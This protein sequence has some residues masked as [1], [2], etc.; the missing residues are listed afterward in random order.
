M[1]FCRQSLPAGRNKGSRITSCKFCTAPSY[2]SISPCSLQQGEPDHLVQVLHSALVLVNV[3]HLKVPVEEHPRLGTQEQKYRQVERMYR[4][5]ERMYRQVDR[6]YRQVEMMYRQ[7]ERMYR[8]VESMRRQV[9]RMHRQLEMMHRQVER[10][11]R[12]VEMMHR[13]VE[14]M[15]RQVEMMP[16]QVE[17]MYR[18][19]EMM[20]RQVEMMRRQVE[21]M[22][23]QV[24]RMHRQLEMMYRQVE[25]MYRQRQLL[26][27]RYRPCRRIVTTCTHLENCFQTLRSL[28]TEKESSVVRDTSSGHVTSPT[29]EPSSWHIAKLFVGVE[30]RELG[31]GGELPASSSLVCDDT[32]DEVPASSSLV[33]DETQDKVPASSSLVCDETQDEVPA[34]SSLVCDETQ[35]EVPASSSLVCDD[36]QDE[37]PASSSLVCDET[38]DKVPASSSLVCDETQDEV[39]AS[40]SLVC[41]DTALIY[42]PILEIKIKFT[43]DKVPSPLAMQWSFV[44]YNLEWMENTGPH[45]TPY[46]AEGL[47]PSLGSVTRARR[48]SNSTEERYSPPSPTI[49]S[50]AEFR[51]GDEWKIYQEHRKQ[52]FTTDSIPDDKEYQLWSH[53]LEKSHTRPRRTNTEE[54][55]QRQVKNFRGHRDI[56]FL[57]EERV[58]ARNYK[59]PKKPGWQ[60]ASINKVPGNRT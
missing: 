2:S 10:M 32:Q 59:N 17:M 46:M 52:Y 7:V 28:E 58:L 49:G 47:K 45:G 57:K 33:C 43:V 26:V 34:S 24:E 48:R 60:S 30:V 18:Q 20:Y 54:A 11:R 53:S 40:S 21:S 13:Q 38:Q 16:R 41:D 12:Q 56:P 4:Q 14:R 31:L 27:E 8:Q 25:R 29:A 39:P 9:E 50:L 3:D 37:V 42:L 5:L 19:V 51:V 55:R 23:R 22:R 15:Y 1:I 35:D 44:L 36:T 6:M